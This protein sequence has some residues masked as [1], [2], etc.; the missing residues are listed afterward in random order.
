M[1]HG[2]SGC[3]P[4]KTALS[5]QGSAVGAAVEPK[6]SHIDPDLQAIIDAWPAL[7]DEVKANIL[8]A[9]RVAEKV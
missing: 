9:V 4:G 7:A 5:G 8:A 2:T 1:S 6:T 3:N